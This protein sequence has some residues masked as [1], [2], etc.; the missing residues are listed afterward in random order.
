P[1][2]V[3]EKGDLQARRHYLFTPVSHPASSVA[4]AAGRSN[5]HRA[6]SRPRSAG[7]DGDTR[8]DPVQAGGPEPGLVAGGLS[9]NHG[10]MSCPSTNGALQ[11]KPRATPWVRGRSQAE[12]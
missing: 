10:P 5:H 9:V 2:I 1:R 4:P 3:P 7:R 6:R 11:P 12:P 8:T